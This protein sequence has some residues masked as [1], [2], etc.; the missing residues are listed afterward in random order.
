MNWLM[1]GD[2]TLPLGFNP[3]DW[4]NL[5]DP[6]PTPG[7]YDILY[8]NTVGN[9]CRDAPPQGLG[10]EY[11]SV[12]GNAANS[13]MAMAW[14]GLCEC[15]PP[16]RDREQQCQYYEALALSNGATGQC[17]QWYQ[18]GTRWKVKRYVRDASEETGWRYLEDR[19][20][21]SR[22]VVR[23]P[24]SAPVGPTDQYSSNPFSERFW[25]FEPDSFSPDAQVAPRPITASYPS[26]ES[27]NF[28]A[29]EFY[30]PWPGPGFQITSIV[31]LGTVV[32]GFDSEGNAIGDPDY[33]LPDTCCA[34]PPPPPPPPDPPPLPDPIPDPETCTTPECLEDEDTLTIIIIQGTPG[35]PGEDGIDGQDGQNGVDGAMGP[36]G[37]MGPMGPPGE[38]G[39][40]GDRGLP[41]ED[42]SME[43]FTITGSITL[44]PPESEE[45]PSL[46]A[47]TAEGSADIQIKLPAPMR[48]LSAAIDPEAVEP[49]VARTEE[50]PPGNYVLLLPDDELFIP[51][52]QFIEEGEDA[53]PI[54]EMVVEDDVRYLRLRLPGAE[55]MGL[56]RKIFNLLG[57]YEWEF[58]END[59]PQ[60][61]INPEQ[62]LTL[63]RDYLYASDGNG[64]AGNDHSR[65][66]TVYTLP[67]LLE[68]LMAVNHHRL[69]AS[70]FP[71]ESPESLLS[72]TDGADLIKHHDLASF[73]AWFLKQFDAVVGEFPIKIEIEDSDPLQEGNQVQTIELPNLSEAIAEL[74]AIAQMSATSSD[75]SINFLSRLAAEVIA[76][77][78]S[79]LITQDFVRAQA[80]FMGFK[81]NSVKRKITYNFDPKHLDSLAE[82]LS[83]SEAYVIGYKND[84]PETLVGFLQ[85]LLFSA[86]IIKAAFMR[87][88][89]QTG[90][91]QEQI[92]AMLTR[93]AAG[94][95]EGWDEFIQRINTS[96]SRFNA[97][98]QTPQPFIR[99]RSIDTPEP[100]DPE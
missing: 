52:L 12:V 85:R 70:Q 38:K 100:G 26:R 1:G 62:L 4:E 35:P 90:Q 11:P 16:E 5:L 43:D 89:G 14:N 61:T 82:F 79:S 49:I 48:S 20:G 92:E 84:D 56:A 88:S 97:D 36:P 75:L 95:D 19:E 37:P 31:P 25:L 28:F 65:D 54:F 30:P 69:G 47:T 3:G 7:D 55:D 27:G 67:E 78:N 51:Q 45:V 94:N 74:Y 59:R 8:T 66:D 71:I 57:G 46:E 73:Q 6:E 60:R 98:E 13:W 81:G 18:I 83:E 42:G 80:D 63:R 44:Y 87:P 2:R 10:A 91:V 33:I 39:E 64:D 40:P 17:P 93:D 99:D 96:T 21:E 23:G 72:Y 53:F 22:Y 24:I 29:F 34:M 58:D 15:A 77:K 68:A 86:G 41:G 9:M 50:T 76:T 32:L